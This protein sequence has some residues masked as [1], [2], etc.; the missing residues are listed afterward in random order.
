MA[1]QPTS[2]VQAQF[3]TTQNAL[4]GKAG[5]SSPIEK[6][7]PAS[8]LQAVQQD[9]DAANAKS[10]GKQD[11]E[12]LREAIKRAQDAL[13]ASSRDIAFS[14]NEKADTVVIKIIDRESKEV[15]RQIPSEEFLKIAEALEDRMEDIRAGL[16]VEQKA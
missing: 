6:A 3:A 12:S 2:P 13:P 1:I 8:K 14:M 11:A 7:P 15:I 16:L 5:A 10:A 4:A 9:A